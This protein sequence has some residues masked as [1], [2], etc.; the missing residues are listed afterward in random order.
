M[1]FKGANL[2]SNIFLFYC[3]VIG[4]HPLKLRIVNAFHRLFKNQIKV[5]GFNNTLLNLV[6]ND[7]I[8]GRIIFSEAYEPMSLN[9]ALEVLTKSNG[10]FIDV[11][12]NIGLYTSVISN[13]FKDKKIVAIEPERGNYEILNKNIAL[14]KVNKHKVCTLNIAVGSTTKLIQLECPVYNNNGTFRVVVDESNPAGNYYPMLDL[15]TVFKN[16]NIDDISLMKID[17]EGFEMEVFKGM[18]WEVSYKP[19]NIIMEFSDYV[20]R[21][22]TTSDEIMNFLTVK[23]YKPYTV[24]NKPY[25]INNELPEDN[26]IFTLL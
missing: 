18:N 3:R 19:K 15:N 7:Y 5:I 22:G 16:L 13:T 4:G 1:G 24:D 17:V 9:L 11:G 23:G 12:A 21:T 26:L 2:L 8:S 10:S 6:P 25:L 14:N 20:S